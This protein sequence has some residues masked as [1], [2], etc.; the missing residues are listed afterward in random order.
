MSQ[1]PCLTYPYAC[2]FGVDLQHATTEELRVSAF[3]CV[4]QLVLFTQIHTKIIAGTLCLFMVCCGSGSKARNAHSHY[5]VDEDVWS[6]I[7]PGIVSSAIYF[8]P[9]NTKMT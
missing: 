6:I 4:S 3:P 7:R 2:P 1:L 9:S 8:F 5:F